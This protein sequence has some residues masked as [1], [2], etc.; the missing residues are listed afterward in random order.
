MYPN[1]E[2]VHQLWFG[3]NYTIIKGVARNLVGG[4]CQGCTPYDS[5]DIMNRTGGVWYVTVYH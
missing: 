2:E 3:V 1:H 4:Y 5:Y